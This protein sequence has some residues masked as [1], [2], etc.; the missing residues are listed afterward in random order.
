MSKLTPSIY[1]LGVFFV[2][3]VVWFIGPEERMMNITWSLPGLF[4]GTFTVLWNAMAKLERR[5]S[6]LESEI[7]ELKDK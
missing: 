6:R 3:L 4:V 1:F 7:Q 5:I 2:V